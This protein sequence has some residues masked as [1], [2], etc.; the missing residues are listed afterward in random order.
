MVYNNT[1]ITLI[2]FCNKFRERKITATSSLFVGIFLFPGSATTTTSEIITTTTTLHQLIPSKVEAEIPC[3]ARAISQS[4]GET[5][6]CRQTRLCR[7]ID[8]TWT[9]TAICLR[10]L[11]LTRF[12]SGCFVPNVG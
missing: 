8:H 9:D 6:A 5:D 11:L 7:L 3:D 12:A 2:H 1:C 4:Y 10:E